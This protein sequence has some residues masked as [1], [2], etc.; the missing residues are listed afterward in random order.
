MPKQIHP[1]KVAMKACTKNPTRCISVFREQVRRLTEKIGPHFGE[2]YVE[3]S[4]A[5]IV[6]H[7]K[8][9]SQLVEIVKL[10]ACHLLVSLIVYTLFRQSVGYEKLGWFPLSREDV[11][12]SANRFCR[13]FHNLCEYQP[14]TVDIPTVEDVVE[15]IG[16]FDPREPHNWKICPDHNIPHAP[17]A[18]VYN[19]H[20][21][22]WMISYAKNYKASP[23][24][25]DMSVCHNATDLEALR[26]VYIVLDE[27]VSRAS[28][29]LAF[30][31]IFQEERY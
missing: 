16:K 18:E 9:I 13:A 14:V 11:N 22:H 4:C 7:N 2:E 15:W 26:E 10:Q 1:T 24:V 19:G 3:I 6:K 23:G 8:N 30:E 17:T 20:V 5:H 12:H 29:L 25:L 31:D 21:Q 28:K 27:G